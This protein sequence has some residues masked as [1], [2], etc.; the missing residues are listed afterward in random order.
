MSNYIAVDLGAESGRIIV[1][2][3]DQGYLGLEEIYRFQNGPVN[4][5]QSLRWDIDRIWREILHGIKLACSRFSDIDSI[6]VNTWGV[7]YVLLDS[8]GQPL[9]LPYHYRDA[10]T[11]H[12]EEEVFAIVP[13]DELYYLTGIQTMPLNTLFQLVAFRKEYP[14]MF[15]KIHRIL[16]MPDFINYKFTGHMANEYTIASTSQLLDMRKGDYSDRLLE[17]LSIPRQIFP[18]LSA[19]G[20]LLGTLRSECARECK[21]GAIPVVAVASHD[22]ASAVAS[23][24]AERSLNWAYLSSGTWSL[25]GIESSHVIINNKTM[26]LQLTNEG[27]YNNTIRLLKNLA[28][29]WLVQECRRDWNAQGCSYDYAELS[30]MAAV[31]EPFLAFL[32]PEDR[33]F[34]N[35]GEMDKRIREYLARTGQSNDY[36]HAQIIRIILEGLA[37]R[38]SFILNQLEDVSGKKIDVLHIVGGGSRNEL[39]NQMTADAT[40]INVISGPVE[41]TVCGNVMIQAMGPAGENSLNQIRSI[42]TNS[43]TFKT[44]YP[45]AHDR[46]VEI[47]PEFLKVCRY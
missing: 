16:Y 39:L 4:Y 14:E 32:N 17:A 15:Q 45:V 35:P 46:W 28:G 20:T 41:A 23:I 5:A 7:D 38:Y 30:Q 43:F 22:T 29:L 18:P 44:Y 37:F 25:M 6:G 10:R 11:E 40:G 33:S 19:P 3:L 34:F 27:G 1:G 26:E 42:V 13:S 24:P 31:A 8:Q 12:I 21:C 36:N 47:K 9:G 2:T